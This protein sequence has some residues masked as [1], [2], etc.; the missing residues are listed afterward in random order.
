MVVTAASHTC[1]TDKHQCRNGRCIPERW[2]CDGDNDCSDNS[3]EV[4]GFADVIAP[5][6]K[7][8]NKL[9]V[10]HDIDQARNLR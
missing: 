5:T 1:G 8:G 9:F 4:R 6:A 3:D 10:C 2:R 7:Y